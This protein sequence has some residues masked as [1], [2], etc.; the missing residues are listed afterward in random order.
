MA[1][2]SS[3]LKSS[4]RRLL[5]CRTILQ[6]QGK[7]FN[8]PLFRPHSDTSIEKADKIIQI[9]WANWN[10]RDFLV[11]ITVKNSYFVFAL[12]ICING[13]FGYFCVTLPSCRPEQASIQVK[14]MTKLK[15]KGNIDEVIWR[16]LSSFTHCVVYFFLDL[17]QYW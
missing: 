11:V 3:Y 1:P 12:P 4:S 14:A 17:N 16:N 6:V 10:F 2:R 9:Q 5:I 15:H 8:K 7:S 13:L